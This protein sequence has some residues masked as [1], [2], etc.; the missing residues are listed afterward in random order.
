M[1]NLI[2]YPI[3]ELS[4]Y[5]DC[6]EMKK[7]ANINKETAN[8]FIFFIEE[9]FKKLIKIAREFDEEYK[10]WINLELLCV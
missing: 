10:V 1:F 3:S 5:F 9:Q 7:E 6:F 4:K 2:E 8:I